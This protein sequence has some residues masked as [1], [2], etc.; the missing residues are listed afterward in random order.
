VWALV[1]LFGAR[2][3]SSIYIKANIYKNIHILLHRR[4]CRNGRNCWL[5]RRML[6][7]LYEVQKDVGIINDLRLNP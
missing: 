6:S 2:V 7:T 4:N 5:F 1:W 3:L